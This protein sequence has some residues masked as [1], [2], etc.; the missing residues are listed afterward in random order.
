LVG[1]AE[2]R[3]ARWVAITG[4]AHYTRVPGILGQ[5]GISK[6]VG[7]ND[8]GGVAARVRVMLGR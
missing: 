6:E 3:V 5:G 8:L 2:F 4:D 1:G 7:E